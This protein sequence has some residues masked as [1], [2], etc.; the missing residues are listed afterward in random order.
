MK[1][2]T[3]VE[4]FR[5]AAARALSVVVVSA[6]CM[7]AALAQTATPVA[8]LD[9]DGFIVPWFEQARLQN[10]REK[11]CLT[12]NVVLYSLG[13]KK[14]TFQIVTSCLVKNANWQ[15]WN[16]NG[17]LDPAGS[18]RLKLKWIW[19]FTHPYWVVATGPEMKWIVVGTPNH[20]S[21][22]L[23]SRDRAAAPEV[24][25]EMRSR[26]AAEGYDVGKLIPVTQHADVLSSTSDD[27]VTTAQPNARPQTTP[28]PRNPAR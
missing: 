5:C 16:Q 6:G 24:L 4:Q 8:K 7:A 23:L 3:G 15:S 14:N 13:D 22:W 10:K 18:G 1:R 26:A 9:P 20:K 25:A 21:V 11:P 27:G 12:D 19:P 17:K 28:R 2:Q